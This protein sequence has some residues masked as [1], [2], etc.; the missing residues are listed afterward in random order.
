MNLKDITAAAK[1]A[2]PKVP[3][4]EYREAVEAL[5]NKGYTWREVA[6]FLQERGVAADHTR[7]Y[8]HFGNP[9]TN[10]VTEEREVE[11]QRF[12]YLGEKTKKSKKTWDVF[13]IELPSSL[14]GPIVLLGFAMGGS[15]SE[16]A[17]GDAVGVRA[18]RLVTK[19][20]NK[21][22][23]VAFLKAELENDGADWREQE[24]YVAPQW[25]ALL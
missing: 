20:G 21:G 3:L 22:F 9:T 10:R 13:E 4:E 1:A 8:R 24:I 19:S 5:R 18:S 12:T 17:E 7:I 6:A 25:D 11:V 23:P 16:R 2:P 14:G 15:F